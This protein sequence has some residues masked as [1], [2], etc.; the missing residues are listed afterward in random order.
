METFLSNPNTLVMKLFL[1]TLLF[2]LAA[3]SITSCDKDDDTMEPIS[4][5]KAVTFSVDGTEACAT[6][7][8][9]LGTGSSTAINLV[10]DGGTVLSI[11][12]LGGGVQTI[13]I[14]AGGARYITADGTVY[15]STNGGIL[16]VT[17]NAST[18]DATFNFDAA[19]PDGSTVS[20]TSGVIVDLPQ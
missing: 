13:A 16:D 14:P 10:V 12:V 20:I 6:G 19:S 4:C 3:I 18:L 1:H 9:T 8:F 5:D 15:S 17:D 11:A 2:C 7:T